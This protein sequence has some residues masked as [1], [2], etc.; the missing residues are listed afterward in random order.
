MTLDGYADRFDDDLD[1]GGE[2]MNGLLIRAIGE[3]RDLAA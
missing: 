1:A 3:G 2:A